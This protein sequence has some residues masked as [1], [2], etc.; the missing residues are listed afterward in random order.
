MARLADLGHD[1]HQRAPG[2]LGG[3]TLDAVTTISWIVAFVL[4][5]VTVTGL[6]GRIGW[7]APVGLVVVG[8]AASFI[9]GIPQVTV[10]SELILYGLLPP[11]LFAAAIRTSILDVRAR[12][13]SILILSVGLV[14][15]TVV[16]VGFATWLLIP[17][18]TLAAG[19]AF[20]AV[21]AP[22][23][24]VAVTAIA[25]RVGLP[26]RVV[27]ILEG[28]SL[29]NDATALVALNA[30][31]AAIVSVLN[32]TTVAIDFVLAVVGGG[33]VGLGIGFVVSRIRRL[34]RSPVLDTSLSL[35]TPFL[36]FLLAELIHGSGVLAVVIA[37]LYLGFTAPTVASAEARVAEQLNWRTIQFLLENAV[38]LFIGLNLAHIVKA[39]AVTGPGLW[40]TIGI[41]VAVL[42]ILLVSRAA[43]VLA[44]TLVYRH[45]PKRLRERGWSW[46]NAI[47]VGLA[48]VRGVV[49]LAAVF[50]LPEQTP[51]R[52]FLQ[53]LAFVVVVASLIGGLALPG[54]IRALRLP[55]PNYMQETTERQQL[56]AEARRA[57]ILR[58][59][60]LVTVDDE[61]RVVERLRQDAAFLSDTLDNY[62]L[63]EALPQLKS[64]QR[65]RADMIAAERKAVLAARREG[66]YREP[67][68]IAVLKSIDAEETALRS[69]APKQPG[70]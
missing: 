32:P 2:I 34:L 4:V 35:V 31:I 18:L 19:F 42:L 55:A 44:I 40:P 61:A 60:E 12:R 7:S 57:G 16:V 52:E 6:T 36:A 30:T 37:G 28:E 3:M 41:C 29:L 43:W 8:G 49:T 33:A 26:R 25:G 11:L 17:A 54:I 58:L 22:T 59:D 39:A 9:P 53:F 14:A 10:Q 15:F 69:A 56:M 21:V 67:A 50:L 23:D 65:L 20:A 51:A 5:T 13:D 64:Y 63:E 62:A 45:G 27:T 66:R 38:F 1:R 47:V 70:T 68:I 24:A 48:G 46:R